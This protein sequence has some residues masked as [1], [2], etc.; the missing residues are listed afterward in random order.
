MKD[1]VKS[2]T[3]IALNEVPR[4]PA[5]RFVDFLRL[6]MNGEFEQRRQLVLFSRPVRSVHVLNAKYLCTDAFCTVCRRCARDM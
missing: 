6:T 1:G 2:T 5:R 4:K 3:S